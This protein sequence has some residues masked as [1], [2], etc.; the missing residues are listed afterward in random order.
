MLKYHFAHWVFPV[1]QPPIADGYLCTE[2]AVITAVGSTSTLPESLQQQAH[3]DL[4]LCNHV[5]LL[6]PGLINTHAHLELTFDAMIPMVPGQTMADWLMG[7]IATVQKHNH[8]DYIIQRCKQGI[9]AMLATGTTCVNDISQRGE[10]L[11]LLVAAGMRGIV[12]LEF[13]HPACDPVQVDDT[14]AI[15]DTHFLPYA[16]HPR[17]IP[18]LSP[19]APYNVSPQAWQQMVS[20]CN[21]PLLHT[22]LAESVDELTWLCGQGGGVEVMHQALLGQTYAPDWQSSTT[23]RTPVAYLEQHHLL[24]NRMVVAHGIEVQPHEIPRL[25]KQGVG[26]AHC[27]RSNMML[28]QKT[29]HWPDWA[30]SGVAM[31][32]GT[33]STLS[34]PNLDLREEARFAAQHHG[35][36][37]AEALYRATLGGAQALKWDKSIGSLTPGKQADFAFWQASDHSKTTMP[38][39][40]WLDCKTM[41]QSLVVAGHPLPV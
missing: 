36:D 17:V 38:G 15:Y 26:V 22:H 29:L 4:S 9:A 14:V 3:N 41:L 20:R 28:H 21:P 35:W 33:D 6:T 23:D 2:G 1:D 34:T 13:F 30:S 19:H 25:V 18:G 32:L 39:D 31:G 27:P 24:N 37:A 12:S 40:L 7:V 5:R 11:P 10:S 16:S 8:K